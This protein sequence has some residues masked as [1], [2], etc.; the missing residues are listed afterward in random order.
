M[1]KNFEE[2][3]VLYDFGI[4]DGIAG[5]ANSSNLY[6]KIWSKMIERCYSDG[7]HLRQPTYKNVIV[8]DE[9][10]Y[11]SNFEKWAKAN[12]KDGYVLDKD[13][14]SV[15]TK[16]YSPSTCCFIPR[17]I[18]QSIIDTNKNK[19]LPLGVSHSRGKYRARIRKFG[20]LHNIGS[21]DYPIEAH[22]SWQKAKIEYFNEII[23]LF[24]NAVDEKVIISIKR[25]I[26]I[27]ENDLKTQKITESFNTILIT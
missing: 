21:F 22:I 25:R 1:Y 5:E 23:E 2:F 9:W 27:I 18:N 24:E 12:Y 19:E 7:Y 15:D 16:I 10:K 13:L 3:Y 6:Y 4:Y 26:D 14:L 20:E 8:C 11:F 17:T